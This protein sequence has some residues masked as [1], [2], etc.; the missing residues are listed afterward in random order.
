MRFLV[1]SVFVLSFI[2]DLS[3][4]T[5]CTHAAPLHVGVPANCD[6]ILMPKPW[7]EE[8]V[9]LK[10]V[11]LPKCRADVELSMIEISALKDLLEER[12]VACENTIAE[13][14]LAA[15]EAAGLNKSSMFDSFVPWLTL[16]L[17]SGFAL[18]YAVF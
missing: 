17:V 9:V 4:E 18:G 6:G 16:G 11:A 1:S 2:C 5:L 13:L 10:E 7:V 3:A 8:C 12:R 14:E 15:R